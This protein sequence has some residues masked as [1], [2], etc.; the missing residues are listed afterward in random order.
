MIMKCPDCNGD[1]GITR[2]CIEKNAEED[3]VEVNFTC[4]WCNVEYFAV[5]RPVDFEPV[6]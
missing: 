5:L 4:P 3:G 6:D 2:L 1:V